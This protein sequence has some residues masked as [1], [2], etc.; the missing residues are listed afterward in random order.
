[1]RNEQKYVDLIEETNFI[2][3]NQL[4]TNENIILFT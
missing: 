1:M 4:M 2:E 3:E